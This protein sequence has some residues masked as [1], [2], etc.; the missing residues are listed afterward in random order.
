MAPIKVVVHGAF[1]RMGKEA[2]NALCREPNTEP[3]G[4][5][6]RRAAEDYLSLPDG[7]GLIPLANELAPIITRCRPQVVV[8]FTN[9]Q[10][11][12]DSIRLAAAKKVSVVTGTTGLSQSDLD[13]A[14]ALC[15]EHQVGVI[16][17]P[18]FALGAILLIHLARQVGRFFDYADIT[19][20]HH[21]AKMD[22][23]SGTAL[24]IARSLVEGKGGAFKAPKPEKE[25]LVG[26]RGGEY[27]G[28]TIHS[29]RMPGKMAYHDL[30]LGALGQTLS[31]RHDTISR[32][33]YMPGVIMAVQE[34]IKSKGLV[35]GLDKVLGL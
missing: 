35:V 30:V 7:S 33:C 8:D 5:V 22:A 27:E 6:S 25:T 2:L 24:A 4:A 11:A 17:A 26:T 20:I 13:E 32:E 10:A 23:P 15:R 31:I 21:E 16:V 1:G 19:E 29:G 14:D 34:V 18:N 28:V 3:V 9:A 12:M